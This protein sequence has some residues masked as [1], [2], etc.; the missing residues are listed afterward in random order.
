MTVHKH[1]RGKTAMSFHAFGLK[2]RSLM[3]P[4]TSR[5]SFGGFSQ[6]VVKWRTSRRI[7]VET[8]L[9]NTVA[10]AVRIWMEKELPRARRGTWSRSRG[11]DPSR[12]PTDV[13]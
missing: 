2:L 4:E 6:G 10:E 3:A 8:T 1:D 11:A 7:S 5:A 9:R 12:M 13:N